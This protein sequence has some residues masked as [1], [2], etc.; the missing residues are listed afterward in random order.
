MSPDYEIKQIDVQIFGL[1]LLRERGNTPGANFLDIF[2]VGDP[3]SRCAPANH[4][5]PAIFYDGAYQ[6]PP[7]PGLEK[8]TLGCRK[9]DL[10]WLRTTPSSSSLPKNLVDLYEVTGKPLPSFP[11]QV[12][13]VAGYVTLLGGHRDRRDSPGRKGWGL[14]ER[15]GWDVKR[16]WDTITWYVTWSIKLSDPLP[17]LDW[18][19]ESLPG[20]SPAPR[21]PPLYA[22]DSSGVILLQVSNLPKD[23]EPPVD[24]G[25]EPPENTYV[26]HFAMFE[27]LYKG[28]GGEWPYLVYAPKKGVRPTPMREGDRGLT[29]AYT[30]VPSGGK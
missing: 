19:V 21:T 29:T 3:A 13:S 25:P 5:D 17:R 20:G 11:D 9:L 18:N 14:M 24:P 1:C 12:P 6:R 2:L 28:W 8:Q 26:S 10:T 30:C 7:V 27:N 4:H 16:R 22:K 23:K 15:Q